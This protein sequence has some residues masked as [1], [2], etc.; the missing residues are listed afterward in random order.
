M[1]NTLPRLIVRDALGNQREVEIART[2]FTLG[3]QSD[4]DLVLLDNRISRRHARI[5]NTEKGHLIGEP[6]RDRCEQ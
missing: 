2:P 4:S 3:R 1:A 6:A 5:V